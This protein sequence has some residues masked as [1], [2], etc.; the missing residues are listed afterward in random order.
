MISGALQ[1]KIGDEVIDIARQIAVR[2]APESPRWLLPTER[3][4]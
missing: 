1:F 3:S 2:I 4:S